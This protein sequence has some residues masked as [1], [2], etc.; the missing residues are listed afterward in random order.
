MRKMYTIETVGRFL[1]PAEGARE[2]IERN[3]R[4]TNTMGDIVEG[5]LSDYCNEPVEYVNIPLRHEDESDRSF[6]RCLGCCDRCDV[7]DVE[8]VDAE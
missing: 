2:W 1:S 7:V 4:R 5:K 8:Y 3:N 6:Y